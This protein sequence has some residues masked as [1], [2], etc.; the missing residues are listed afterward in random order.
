MVLF[1]TIYI[2][3]EQFAVTKN[4][5]ATRKSKGHISFFRAIR[6][7]LCKE[8]PPKL[9]KIEFA[10]ESGTWCSN[11]W[12]RIMV[13]FYSIYIQK[14]QIAVTKNDH[15]VRKSQGHIS[16]VRDL[17]FIFFKEVPPKLYKIEFALELDNQ[18]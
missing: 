4:D 2:Q 16:L 8:D 1:Y 5:H 18:C 3:K 17:G 10:L 6:F 9:Y 7:I 11:G 14:E 13:L 15:A 12:L